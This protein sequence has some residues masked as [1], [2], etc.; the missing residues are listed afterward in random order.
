MNNMVVGLK[1]F[2]TNKNTVTVIG[3][4]LAILVLYFGYNVRINSAVKPT[5]LPYA[6]KTIQ[7]RTKITEDMIGYINVPAGMIKGDILKN[8]KTIENKYS[9]VN[10]LIPEGS[11]FYKGSVVELKALPD[12]FKF[13]IKQGYSVFNLPVTAVGSFGILPDNYIDIYFKAVGDDGK[14][15]VG[16]MLENVKVSVV[17]D[18]NGKPVYENTEENRLA[19][20]LIFAVPEEM[21]LLLRKA[22]Y[23]TANKVE[24]IPV[25]TNASFENNDDA[26]K[27]TSSYIKDFVETKTVN[28][29]V[30]QLPDPVPDFNP[31]NIEG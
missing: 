7:P 31:D 18:K 24:L 6:K 17:I 11:L 14:I 30:D 26:V 2:F 22:S 12:A 19:S 23:L 16:K 4:L 5:K 3:V 25:P 13:D 15:M 20:T 29:P 10:A 21:H 9:N 1:R 28:V 8:G 27:I